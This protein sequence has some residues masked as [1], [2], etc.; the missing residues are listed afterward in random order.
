MPEDEEVP[1]DEDEALSDAVEVCPLGV[2]VSLLAAA[3]VKSV[4]GALLPV[5]LA[6]VDQVDA[7]EVPHEP[8]AGA[9]VGRQ[10]GASSTWRWRRGPR[11]SPCIRSTRG[12]KILSQAGR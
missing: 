12:R 11:A 6:A 10:H 2:E 3:V 5:E 7:A 1:E 4:D 9:E 8:F